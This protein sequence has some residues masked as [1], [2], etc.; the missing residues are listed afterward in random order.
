M[1]LSAK[2]G[3]MAPDFPIP[4]NYNVTFTKPA[5]HPISTPRLTEQVEELGLGRYD[6]VTVLGGV[7]YVRR[8][9]EAYRGTGARIEAPFAGYSNA[10]QE[11]MVNYVLQEDLTPQGEMKTTV[12]RRK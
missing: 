6:E 9:R 11:H 4:E 2:Y 7:E 5:T 8:I 12:P 10:V 3:F 1:I